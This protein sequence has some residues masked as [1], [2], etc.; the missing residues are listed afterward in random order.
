MWTAHCACYTAGIGSH[1]TTG[2]G[3]AV[4]ASVVGETSACLAT[5]SVQ[6]TRHCRAQAEGGRAAWESHCLYKM[7]VMTYVIAEVP[8]DLTKGGTVPRVCLEIQQGGLNY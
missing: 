5:Q 6:A 8:W 7:R 4:T 3:S 2:K 1:N